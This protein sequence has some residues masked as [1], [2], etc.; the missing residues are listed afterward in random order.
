[1]NLYRRLLKLVKPHWHRLAIAMVCMVGVAASRSVSV[2]LIKPP[3]HCP[4]QI[5][6]LIYGGIHLPVAGNH[7]HTHFNLL[8]AKLGQ[9]QGISH[10]Q[11]HN[12]C[13]GK[14][15]QPTQNTG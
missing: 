15:P 13:G 14:P 4:D 5:Y 2:Y 9:L 7:R 3:S 1:M 11:R 8:G 10:R 6:R 12:L